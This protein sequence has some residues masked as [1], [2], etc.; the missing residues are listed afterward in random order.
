VYHNFI[1]IYMFNKTAKETKAISLEENLITLQ[2]VDIC[3]STHV[4]LVKQAESSVLVLRV[5]RSKTHVHSV[6]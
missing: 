1:S 3:V 6:T 5:C 2:D 4:S